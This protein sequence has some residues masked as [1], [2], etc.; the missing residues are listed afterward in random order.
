MSYLSVVNNYVKVL[1]FT[2]STLLL[3]LSTTFIPKTASAIGYNACIESKYCD[4]DY[5]NWRG[6]FGSKYSEMVKSQD[7]QV[8]VA[9]NFNS[10]NLSNLSY[11]WAI[12]VYKDNS[13]QDVRTSEWNS[14][15]GNNDGQC[16][17]RGVYLGHHYRARFWLAW[18][19]GFV[20]GDGTIYGYKTSQGPLSR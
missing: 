7:G 13:W 3:I 11:R 10:Y 16:F 5:F 8:C 18:P 1:I 4:T 9:T 2:I 17:D 19:G 12:Q 14:A 15:N 6:G 20:H